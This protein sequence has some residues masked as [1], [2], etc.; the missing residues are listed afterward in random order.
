MPNE[1][2]S[3]G[4]FFSVPKEILKRF[5]LNYEL[6]GKENLGK[7]RELLAQGESVIAII[8]HKSFADLVSGAM[9]TV[10]EQF[11]DLV[12]EAHII[13]K[14]TYTKKFPS[15]QLLKNFK[16]KPVVP[17][18]MPDYPNREEINQE[19]K[20]WAQQLP[21][22]SILITAPEGTRVKEG[23]MISARYGASDF[24]HGVG[25]RWILP[26][27]LEGTEKQWPRGFWGAVKY[28][29]GGFRIKARI[30]IGEPVA[31]A[32]L[33][34]AA[35]IYAQ[36]TDNEE[37]IRL[38]TDLAMLLIANLHQDSKYKGD[39]Y[40]KVQDELISHE[41]SQKLNRFGEIFSKK[42]QPA[43]FNIKTD[44]TR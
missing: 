37:F 29:G 12:K 8:D 30:I 43:S 44:K 21:G 42:D 33:D 31:V 27:A 9:I 18:T 15:K 41:I 14:I 4:S 23:K 16:F 35:E 28:F 7:V 17:H 10:K 20:V 39:Y 26:V 22:G 1:R 13:A 19:A 11:D 25:K 36:G 32:N 40:L 3:K 6:I 38:K 34:K 2:E 24:W 5:P